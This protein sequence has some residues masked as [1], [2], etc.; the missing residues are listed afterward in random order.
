L[1]VAVAGLNS[2]GGVRRADVGAV[3]LGWLVQQLH[4]IASSFRAVL[5]RAVLCRAVLWSVLRIVLWR[6]I[7]GIPHRTVSYGLIFIP[8]TLGYVIITSSPPNLLT[9]SHYNFL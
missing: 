2:S 5:C 8:D 9:D 3:A 1:V 7:V 4:H 6:A